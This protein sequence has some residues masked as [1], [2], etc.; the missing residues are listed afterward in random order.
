MRFWRVWSSLLILTAALG[1]AGWFVRGEAPEVLI[2]NITP[3]DGTPFEQ[4]L[5]VDLRIRNPNDYDLQVTGLDVGV[6]LNGKRLAR[7]LT[8][9]A[10]TVPRLGESVISLETST[11]MLDIVRQV[12]AFRTAQDV[13]YGITGVLHLTDG[14]LPFE[15]TGVLVEK[16]AL[17]GIL[18][19]P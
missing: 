2:T 13:A 1:C 19:P 5:Q 16:S 14:R 7:G 17:S 10:F 6:E 11:S 12:L 9:T 8:N 3:L 18:T 15:H 4:R